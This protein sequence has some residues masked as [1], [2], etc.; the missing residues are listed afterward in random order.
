[1]NPG[2]KQHAATHPHPPRP[3]RLPP[4]QL[5]QPTLNPWTVPPLTTTELNSTPPPHIMCTSS[6]NYIKALTGTTGDPTHTL[7]TPVM[8]PAL[9]MLPSHMLDA[10]RLSCCTCKLLFTSNLSYLGCQV[11]FVLCS[12]IV[13]KITCHRLRRRMQTISARSRPPMSSFSDMN[14]WNVDLDFN[15]A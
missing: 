3:L 4:V 12:M 8:T 15:L 1:M 7:Q 13:K 10:Q 9:Q 2:C 11:F 5:S 14:K 6:A